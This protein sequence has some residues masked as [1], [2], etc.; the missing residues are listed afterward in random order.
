MNDNARQ[1][2]V[3]AHDPELVE[4]KWAGGGLLT[5]GSLLHRDNRAF[6]CGNRPENNITTDLIT[7]EVTGGHELCPNCQWP[8]GAEDVINP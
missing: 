8:D 3:I 4:V 7:A 5:S 1:E 6:A 2:T